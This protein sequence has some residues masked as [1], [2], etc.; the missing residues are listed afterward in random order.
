EAR[1]EHGPSRD[2]AGRACAPRAPHAAAPIPEGTHVWDKEEWYAVCDGRPGTDC[3][4]GNTRPYQRDARAASPT[5]SLAR[6]LAHAG[7]EDHPVPA[8]PAASAVRVSVLRV[9]PVRDTHGPAGTRV[10]LPR[11]LCPGHHLRVPH[12]SQFCRKAAHSIEHFT[13][14][15]FCNGP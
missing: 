2:T 14:C 5:P 4:R 10:S 8:P 6:I 12:P 1:G 13:G 9:S 7:A 11:C 3:V 15:K